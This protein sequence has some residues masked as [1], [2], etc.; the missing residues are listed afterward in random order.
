MS[1]QKTPDLIETLSQSVN[2]VAPLGRRGLWLWVGLSLLAGITYV[3]TAYGA[4][5][6]MRLLFSEGRVADNLSAYAKTAF[7]IGLAALAVWQVQAT[8]RPEGRLTRVQTGLLGLG[9]IALLT[10]TGIDMAVSGLSTALTGLSDGAPGCFLTILVGG[11]VG[12]GVGWAVWL[13]Q[14]APG[15]PALFGA[16]SAFA[17]STLMTVAY[18]LHCDHDAPAYLLLIYLAPNLVA[19]LIGSLIGRALFRW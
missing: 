1:N 9:L 19:A 18:T 6:E 2:P 15:N 17:A 5:P 11:M 14:A 16:L 10:L 13:R 3:L 7:F 8:A 12:L 4:R